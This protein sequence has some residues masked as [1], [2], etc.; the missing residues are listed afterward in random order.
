MNVTELIKNDKIINILRKEIKYPEIKIK[1]DLRYY[2]NPENHSLIGHAYEILFQIEYLKKN[3]SNNMYYIKAFRKINFL[4]DLKEKVSDVKKEKINKIIKKMKKIEKNISNYIFYKEKLNFKDIFYLAW[5]SNIR[6]QKQLKIKN[7]DLKEDVK[8]LKNLKKGIKNFKKILKDEIKFNVYE[9]KED[10]VGEIDIK[11]KKYILDIKTVIDGK[12][13]EYMINQ[14]I[15]Y[16]LISKNEEYK[17]KKIGILFSRFGKIK[18]V[19]IRKILSKEGEKR[20]IKQ[21]L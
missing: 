13:N 1:N 9:K 18:F 10:I 2:K 17:P 16:Y 15:M 8:D 7:I 5:I 3:K 19:K 4:I 14:L 20:L 21:L 11:N 12:I 6:E